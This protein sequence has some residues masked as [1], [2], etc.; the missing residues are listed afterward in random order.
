MNPLR[1]ILPTAVILFCIISVG[2]LGYTLIEEWPFLDALYMVIITMFTVGFSETHDLSTVGRLFTM[3]IIV[4]GVGTAVYAGGQVMEVIVEGEMLGFRRRKKMKKRISE[5]KDHYIICG[6]GRVG[7]Q[8]AEEFDN[9]EVPYVVVDRKP[10]TA[11]QL[12]PRGVPHIIG[13]VISD[14]NLEEAGIRTA[15][16]LITCA[17]SDVA[18]VYVVLSSRALNPNLFIIARASEIESEKK[19]KTAGADRVISPYYIFGKRAAAIALQPVASDFFDMVMHEGE[20]E[21]SLHEVAIPD[22]SSLIDKSLA[23]THITNKTGALILA[24]KKADGSFDLHPK[25][26]TRIEK[27]DI[28]VAIGAPEQITRLTTMLT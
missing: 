2:T 26:T 3:V 22:K 20:L 15:K 28:F 19:L 27:G 14:D 24:I 25:A 13:D 10:E 9:N 21:F 17:D 12:E 8:V 18:N 4:A 5:M 23:E 7:R 6:Y 11:A 16:A 1:R